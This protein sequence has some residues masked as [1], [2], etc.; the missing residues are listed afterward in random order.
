[1]KSKSFNITKQTAFETCKKVLNESDCTII[2]TNFTTGEIEAKKGGNFLSY[3]HKL[4]ITIK[5]INS[6]KIKISISSSSVGVQIIDWGTNADNEDEL[7]GLIS[8]SIR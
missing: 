6:S 1:M 7:I 8:N 3:G 5:S 4:I 2:S